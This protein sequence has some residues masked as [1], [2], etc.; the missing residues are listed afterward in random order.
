MLNEI[1]ELRRIRTHLRDSLTGT[2][3]QAR[4]NDIVTAIDEAAQNII[5][6]AFPD[7][8]TGTI[9]ISIWLTEAATK[10]SLTDTAPLIDVSSIKPRDLDDLR[11]GGLG[12]HF[13]TSLSEAA[14]WSHRGGQNTL[15]LT[16]DH[17]KD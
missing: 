17:P 6:H 15:D 14:E 5:R 12:T 8:M 11:E 7:N 4:L 16:F 13:I 3:A 2:K 9:N 10:I 1:S